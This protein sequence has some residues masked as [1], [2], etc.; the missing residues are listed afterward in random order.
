MAFVN[1]DDSYS[2][3]VSTIDDQHKKLIELV[4][5]LYD[6]MRKGQ[7]L[8]II[9][10]VIDELIHYTKTHFAY[11]EAY[12][13]KFGFEKKEEHKAEHKDF[14]REVEEFKNKFKEG[15]ITLSIE[16]L[17]FLSGWLFTHIKGSDKDYI[18]YF[19]TNGIR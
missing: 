11:E 8:I 13:E 9:G 3:E 16:V 5:Q 7:D 10:E 19:H 15:K 14:V 18:T 17:Q 6:A 1:W 2:V 12:F 4:N